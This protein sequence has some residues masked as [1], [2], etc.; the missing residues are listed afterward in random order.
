MPSFCSYTKAHIYA[1][2]QRQSCLNRGIGD[3]GVLFSGLAVKFAS[4]LQ[5]AST[6]LR[7]LFVDPGGFG[8]RNTYQIL[9]LGEEERPRPGLAG[10][11]VSRAPLLLVT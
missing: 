3:E 5:E 11:S 6:E 2:A 4:T 1:L 9:C 7:M 8:A 10:G